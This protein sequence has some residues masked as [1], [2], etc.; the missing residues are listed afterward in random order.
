MKVTATRETVVQFAPVTM[1]LTLE[2]AEEVRAL[3]ALANASVRSTE[4]IAAVVK[5]PYRPMNTV[6]EGMWGPLSDIFD[7]AENIR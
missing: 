2:S 7:S 1:T 3:Y 6:F 5:Q 4:Q